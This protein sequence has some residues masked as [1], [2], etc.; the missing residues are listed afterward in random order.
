[1]GI[2]MYFGKKIFSKMDIL[3]VFILT[4]GITLFCFGEAR[5]L[6]SFNA[7]GIL[8]MSFGVLADAGTSN[9]EKK[10]IFSDG[11][12]HAEAMFW[13]SLMGTIWTFITL[14]VTD[15][16]KLL[17]AV[18]FCLSNPTVKSIVLFCFVCSRVLHEYFG[19]LKKMTRVVLCSV[20]FC[21]C[22][23]FEVYPTRVIFTLRLFVLYKTPPQK[24]ILKCK[25]YTI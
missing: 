6:P 2:E 7:W 20:C 18:A 24:N 8:L 17:Q 15:Y 14:I 16:A 10:S 12:S 1:M 4:F 13:A 23:F 21:F 25:K 22:F 5:D 19:I 3:N 11:T 9:Y